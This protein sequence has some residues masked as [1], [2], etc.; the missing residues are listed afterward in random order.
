MS[1]GLLK[2]ILQDTGKGKEEKVDRRKGGKTI[3]KSR[4]NGLLPAQLG[5]LKAGLV[6]KLSVV[7]LRPS[8]VMD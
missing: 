8:N 2:P 4:R 6:A 1:T 3:L 5:Q 7:P